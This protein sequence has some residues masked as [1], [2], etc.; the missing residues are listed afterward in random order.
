MRTISRHVGGMSV[1]CCGDRG[2]YRILI[3]MI[4]FKNIL[5]RC[6]IFMKKVPGK[7]FETARANQISND[8]I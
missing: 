8:G 2:I 6:G 3:I 4:M 1:G 7:I 5:M